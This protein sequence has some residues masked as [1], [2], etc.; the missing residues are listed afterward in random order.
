MVFLIISGVTLTVF[1]IFNFDI[2]NWIFG[3]D[4][5][6]RMVKGIVGVGTLGAVISFWKN[7]M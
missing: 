3:V 4:G 1:G 6:S 2:L 7:L 5:G